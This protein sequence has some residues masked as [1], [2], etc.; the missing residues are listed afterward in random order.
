MAT[1]Q[2]KAMLPKLGGSDGVTK[3][4]PA[5]AVTPK[6]D[7]P[8]AKHAAVTA[9]RDQNCIAAFLKDQDAKRQKT[10]QGSPL[11]APAATTP[12][13]PVPT[14][15]SQIALSKDPL[16]S[17]IRAKVAPVMPGTSAP[18]T[19]AGPTVSNVIAA[20]PAVAAAPEQKMYWV[21]PYGKVWST[22]KGPAMLVLT[23]TN[24][25][26]VK[27]MDAIV[28]LLNEHSELETK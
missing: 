17:S 24:E 3:T 14:L 26:T 16:I 8:D 22:R 27:Q 1:E 25:C 23:V 28:A 19:N 4:A 11:V 10:M 5:N 6:T 7:H 18:V 9:A 2:Q 12:A 15:A 21:D 13:P 20:A